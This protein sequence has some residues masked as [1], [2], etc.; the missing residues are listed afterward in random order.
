LEISFNYPKM[1][2][3]K[4]E[5]SSVVKKLLLL[6]VI[7]AFII[8]VSPCW[9]AIP[10]QIN[11]QGML[12]QTDGTPLDGTHDLGFKIYGSESGDDSLWWESHTNIQVSDGL[13][14]IILGSVSTLDLPF[15]TLYWL[16]IRV[17]D[18]PELTPRIQLTSMGYAYRAEWA[19]TAVYAVEAVIA[20]SDS[21]WT[22]SGD[23]M[24][25]AV[26]G[27]V[28]IGTSSPATKL[29][30]NGDININSV[31]EIGGETVLSAPDTSTILVGVDAG[32]N[33]V[34]V[35]ETFLGYQAGYS[36][37]G[38]FNTFL[39]HQAGYTNA[40]GFWNTFVG[41]RAGYSNTEG[42][43]NT[44]IGY[45]AG[46]QNIT[47]NDNTFLGYYAGYSHKTGNDNTFIGDF[48]G[49]SD[50]S[51]TR[52][53]FLGRYAG[54]SNTRAD[55]NTFI[56]CRAGYSNTTGS[57][58]T[59]VGYRAGSNNTTGF[60]NTYS[61]DFAGETNTTGSYNTFYGYCAGYTN[62]GNSNTFLGYRAGQDATG[63]SNVI[64][65]HLAGCHET[66]SNK[67]YIAN[68]STTSSVLIYGD[69]STGWV[70]IG[71]TSPSAGLDV[72]SS[73]GYN[74]LRMRTSYT[75]TGTSDTNGNVGDIAWDDTYIY[76]KTSAGWKRAQLGT[77]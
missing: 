40:T 10:H 23:D 41:H 73:T 7:G 15:D 39:G 1:L 31:Y 60:H 51:S 47:A 16:G 8:A 67:L 49:Y 77:F 26:S 76:I 75:P 13:F 37:Q 62:I 3:L 28:G 32:T 52:N 43:H 5:R 21:D 46:Y 50:T 25:S 56:G 27:N 38:D 11:Y 42:Y 71:T 66:G 22:I 45:Y 55:D 9:G 68:D 72:N 17:N 74:Q 63:D 35:G 59:F 14:S 65:G 53:T 69:F 58:N 29:D 19:D 36:N 20:E 44:F 70:G 12:T 2:T 6:V 48:A 34:G 64:I 4:T 57:R 54:Y 33:N 24:Y 18:D 61:G 30:V